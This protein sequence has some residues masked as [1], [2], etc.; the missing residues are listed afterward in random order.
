MTPFGAPTFIINLTA[1]EDE[2]KKRYCKDKEV[3][4]VPEEGGEEFKKNADADVKLREDLVNALATH[5][6]RINTY[7]LDTAQSI[8]SITKELSNSF[9]PK[10]LLVNHE[11]RLGI[12]TT[13]ANLAI[14][15]NMIYISAYQIIKGHIEG[16]TDWGK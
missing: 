4:E 6:L 5:S 11:K 10:V 14:K 9:L 13:C 12:D 2:I 16:N 1:G 7:H 8:E 15:Y 3:D